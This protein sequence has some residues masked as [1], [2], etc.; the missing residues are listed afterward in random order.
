MADVDRHPDAVDLAEY[1]EGL[2]DEARRQ[3]VEDHVRDCADCTAVLSDLADVPDMLADAPLPPLPDDVADRL[4]QAIDAEAT[5]RAS[6][7]SGTA[8]R[9]APIRR[10]R[11]WLAPVA[12]AAAVIAAIAIVVPSIDIS[13]NDSADSGSE[14]SPQFLEGGSS[15]DDAAAQGEGRAPAAAAPREPVALSSATF[16]RDVIDAFYPDEQASALKR[17]PLAAEPD[18]RTY[19]ESQLDGRCPFDST[20]TTSVSRVVS[21]L[22]DGQR[23]YLL[24]NHAGRLAEAVAFTCDG[25]KA[26]LLASGSFRLR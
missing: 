21:I 4:D 3:V 11:R 16:G 10:A 2:L 24:L 14:T 12:A 5:A 17:S 1:A 9:V 7:W 6:E 13:S 22:F 26:N 19:Y 23:A 18:S 25:P 15:D 8:V 20:Q